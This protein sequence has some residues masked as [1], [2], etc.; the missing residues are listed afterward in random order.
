MKMHTDM[1]KSDYQRGFND[2][3]KQASEA[4]SLIINVLQARIDRLAT[5]ISSAE[6]T[7]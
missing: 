5:P 1:P 6:R 4:A 7:P 2:G 3:Y